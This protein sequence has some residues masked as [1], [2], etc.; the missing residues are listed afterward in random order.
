[1]IVFHTL[2]LH[3]REIAVWWRDLTSCCLINGPAHAHTWHRHTHQTH[4]HKCKH[5]NPTITKIHASCKHIHT[6]THTHN[7]G[8]HSQTCSH[9]IQRNFFSP[10]DCVS[11]AYLT[12]L[13]CLNFQAND[14][15]SS[16]GKTLSCPSLQGEAVALSFLTVNF[17]FWFLIRYPILEWVI[18]SFHSYFLKVLIT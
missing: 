1:M 6:N 2:L 3:L 7:K 8:I 5:T 12:W 15:R 16:E 18:S 14:E 11:L 9:I 10:M 17:A 4:T 13:T